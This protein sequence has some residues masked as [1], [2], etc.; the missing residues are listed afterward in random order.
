MSYDD[1]RHVDDA[2]RSI[3]SLHDRINE[4]ESEVEE[5]EQDKKDLG[6]RLSKYEDV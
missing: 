2:I 6:S 1:D 3:E 4:L 5:L